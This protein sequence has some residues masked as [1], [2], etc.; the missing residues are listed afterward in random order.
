MQNR[1]FS[2]FH[3]H[4]HNK[5]YT[6]TNEWLG[7]LKEGGPLLFIEQSKQIHKYY[8]QCVTISPI[9]LRLLPKVVSLFCQTSFF[10][11]GKQTKGWI[12]NRSGIQILCLKLPLQ[13]LLL[14]FFS[15][16]FP[17][18]FLWRLTPLYNSLF[19]CSRIGMDTLHKETVIDSWGTQTTGGGWY[20][21][22]K[23][24]THIHS[25]RVLRLSR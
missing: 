21:W 9:N 20:Q 13:T 12:E 15:S 7:I 18:L 8:C 10:L 23:A 2:Y 24:M 22:R 3:I 5:F 17:F 1:C 11:Q 25:K 14:C 6:G 16:F 19:A 4:I